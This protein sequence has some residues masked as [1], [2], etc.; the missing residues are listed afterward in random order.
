MYMVFL[1]GPNHWERE[2]HRKE[3]RFKVRG[4]DTAMCRGWGGETQQQ[5]QEGWPD[6][7]EEEA[8]SPCSP[9][10]PAPQ[11]CGK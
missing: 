8:H 5:N 1:K 11:P 9:A 3:K 4:L 7:Q 10:P 2:Y 6:S